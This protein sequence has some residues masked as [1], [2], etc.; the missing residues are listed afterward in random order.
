VGNFQTI[1]SQETQTFG[2]KMYKL[3]DMP[4]YTYDMDKGNNGKELHDTT[5]DM[6]VE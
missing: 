3:C 6:Q 1:H 4:G 5:P 2:I